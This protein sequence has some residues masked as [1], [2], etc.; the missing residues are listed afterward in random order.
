MPPERRVVRVALAIALLSL[1]SACRTITST[2]TPAPRTSPAVRVDARLLAMADA[3][4]ADTVLLDSLLAAPT[5]DAASASRRARAALLVG[6][7]RERSRFS[8]LRALAIDPDTAIAATAAFALGLARD[9]AAVETLTTVVLGEPDGPAAE[10]AWALGALGEPGRAAIERALQ[11]A[12]S[13]SRPTAPVRI[14]ALLRAASVLRPV[15]VARVRPFLQHTHPRV[16]EAAA[17]A[18]AR[19]RAAGGVAGVLAL[20]T[21]SAAEVRAQVAVAASRAATGDSLADSARAVLLAL[22]GDADLQVRVQAVRSAAS[23][24][25]PGD[26]AGVLP[27]LAPDH[28]RLRA[29]LL[30]SLRDPAAPVRA[31]AAEVIAPVLGDD[32]A[33]WRSAFAADTSYMVQRALLDG[34]VRRGLLLPEVDRWQRHDDPW[35]RAAALEW[36]ALLPAAAP[37]LARTEWARRDS[38]PRVRIAAASALA[39]VAQEPA[40]RG[41]LVAMLADSAVFVRS[42]MLSVLSRTATAFEAARAAEVYRRDTSEAARPVRIA[43]LRVIAAAWRRDSLSFDAA[44][45]DE[46]VQWSVPRDPAARAGVR[47]V[48]PLAHWSAAAI[49]PRSMAEYER[50][51][52]RWLAASR[53]ATSARAR[54]HTERGVIT[55]DLLASDA[56]V[57]VDNF[58]QLAR[59]GW[60]DGTRFHRVIPGFVAQDG[61]PTGTGS[62]GPGSTLRDELNRHR[63]ERGAVGMAL[64][65]PDTGGSQYFLTLTPQPHLDG[66]YTVFARV[67]EGERVMDSLL[68][69]DR[70]E[71]V[72]VP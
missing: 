40:A 24:V 62:G 33:A 42:T 19:P 68:L 54:L 13:G 48:T 21:H 15:P 1:A 47:E 36:S 6:Q 35:R 30:Q 51:A 63:Y 70:I 29:A 28:A 20:S 45:R 2:S 18:I 55:L 44:L 7:L 14:V 61:D 22:V 69:G 37:P 32:A 5:A 11:G 26:S 57:T 49:A 71:R 39:S 27:D 38:V 66:G 65:G 8:A 9:T 72:E 67:V 17:Y 31:V 56:P 53:A 34:A 12:E 3:R 46:L 41:A 59:R 58:V 64:S 25:V 52:A 50:I 23:Q 4:R 43:A 16:V 60:F 10:A